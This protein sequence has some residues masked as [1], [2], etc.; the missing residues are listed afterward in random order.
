MQFLGV[1][2]DGDSVQAGGVVTAVA[3]SDDGRFAECDVWLERGDGVRVLEG[4]A[5]VALAD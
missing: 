3:E 2:L 1:V 5:R 4:T